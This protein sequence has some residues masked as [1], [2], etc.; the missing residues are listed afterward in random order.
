MAPKEI[1]IRSPLLPVTL[2]QQNY[3]HSSGDEFRKHT[4]QPTP[5]SEHLLSTE[6]SER[7]ENNNLYI[8]LY[9]DDFVYFSGDI[10]TEQAF[11]PKLSSH[12]EVDFMG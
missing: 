8:G 5:F 9:V 6:K 1:P 2:V 12:L 11:Q 3:V 10:K 7:T 4:S